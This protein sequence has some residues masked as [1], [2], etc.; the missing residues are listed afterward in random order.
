[1]SCESFPECRDCV[2]EGVE[3]AICDECV[4]ADQFE[5]ADTEDSVQAAPLYYHN[6]KKAA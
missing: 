3:P 5:E 1:M 2:F 6:W 4:D